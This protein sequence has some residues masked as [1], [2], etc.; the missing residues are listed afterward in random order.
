MGRREALFEY[1]DGY[2]HRTSVKFN[3]NTRVRTCSCSSRLSRSTTLQV[4]ASTLDCA[5]LIDY[6]RAGMRRHLKSAMD[7][8]WCRTYVKF[9]L[10]FAYIKRNGPWTVQSPCVVHSISVPSP[11][12]SR[13]T[14]VFLKR[15][16]VKRTVQGILFR[17][18]L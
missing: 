3:I 10:V 12:N 5:Q 16:G 4:M 2:L 17:R 11:F 13:L 9:N 14:S 8:D 18:I 1:R 7:I 6:T 15:S